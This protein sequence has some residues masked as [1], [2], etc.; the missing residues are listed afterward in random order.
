MVHLHH[1]HSSGALSQFHIGVA[2]HNHLVELGCRLFQDNIIAVFLHDDVHILEAE[3][4][5][6]YNL[7]LAHFKFVVSFKP[8]DD[9]VLGAYFQD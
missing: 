1:A 4:T 6:A 5:E 2:R 3:E 7:S 9:A 8:G